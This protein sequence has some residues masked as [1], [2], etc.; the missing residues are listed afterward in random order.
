MIGIINDDQYSFAEVEAI[1]EKEYLFKTNYYKFQWMLNWICQQMDLKND[2]LQDVLKYFIL[3]NELY[4]YNLSKKSNTFFDNHDVDLNDYYLKRSDILDKINEVLKIENISSQKSIVRFITETFGKLYL[5][6]KPKLSLNAKIGLGFSYAIIL[7]WSVII[8]FP[9]TL[10]IIQSFNYYSSAEYSG[11]NA[12]FNFSFANFSYLWNE[13]LFKQWLVNSIYIGFI[14][15]TLI[16][17][18]SALSGYVFSR[19]R[20]KGKKLDY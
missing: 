20:F 19:F 8:I 3:K 7:M 13:T 5:S 17:C 1:F 11:K 12:F 4:Y 14:S 6:D 16:I 10:V 15:M 9:I 18:L 2:F